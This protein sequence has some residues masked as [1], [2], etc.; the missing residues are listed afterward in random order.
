MSGSAEEGPPSLR[1]LGFM[2]R[3]LRLLL[4]ASRAGR[5]QHV[6][7]PSCHWQCL[8]RASSALVLGL[9]SFLPHCRLAVEGRRAGVCTDAL[10]RYSWVA[11]SCKRERRQGLRAQTLQLPTCN[12]LTITSARRTASGNCRAA[13]SG[14]RLQGAVQESAIKTFRNGQE[15]LPI[16]PFLLRLVQAEGPGPL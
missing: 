3:L 9:P 6:A 5:M 12:P 16:L 4:S 10:V 15:K 8:H 2:L 7:A 11:R 1:C 14:L 13:V